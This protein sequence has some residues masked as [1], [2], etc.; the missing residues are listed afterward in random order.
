M[1]DKTKSVT[2]PTNYNTPTHRV[3]KGKFH[4]ILNETMDGLVTSSQSSQILSCPSVVENNKRGFDE[5]M[6]VVFKHEGSKVVK[7][8][9]GRET[10]KFGILQSTARQFGYSGDIANLS[11]DEAIQIY[12][13]LWDKSGA[14][15]LPYPLSLVHFDTYINSPSA[16]RKMLIQSEGDVDKYLNLRE[17]RFKRLAELRPERFSKYLKGWLNRVDNLR[18]LVKQYKDS[19]PLAF[20]T[21]SINQ[22]MGTKDFRLL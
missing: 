8:D 7:D 5:M 6:K 19:Q 13:K 3:L 14:G 4:Q 11:K 9:G 17:T 18:T 1:I 15:S 20:D 10:S 12:K 2:E 21:T 22:M 16:A